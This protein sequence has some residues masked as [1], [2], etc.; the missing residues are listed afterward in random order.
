MTR[1]IG[2]LFSNIFK[3]NLFWDGGNKMEEDKPEDLE[4]KTVEEK[5]KD[6][7]EEEKKN[8]KTKEKND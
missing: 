3:K 5:E 6:V 2:D 7:E 1:T 4:E 8:E